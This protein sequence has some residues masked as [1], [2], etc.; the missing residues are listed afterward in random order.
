MEA[1]LSYQDLFQHLA[2]FGESGTGKSVFLTNLNLRHSRNGY[3]F[4]VFDYH[5]DVVR[6]IIAGL[7]PERVDDTIL[8]DLTD[9]EFPIGLNLCEVEGT[10]TIQSVAATASFIGHLF[11]VLF[12]TGLAT[13]PRLLEVLRAV[14]RTL[15]EVSPEACFT[16]IPLLFSD[17]NVRA[18]V[19]S[20]LTNASVVAFWEAY[21][22]LSERGKQEL[23]ES[24]RNKITAFTDEPLVAHILGQASSTIDLGRIMQEGKILLVKLSP[25]YEQA[26]QLV[27]GALLTKLMM[28]GFARA[29][30]PEEQRRPFMLTV[31]EF[32]RV[33]AASSDLKT[34]IHE[35]RKF[36]VGTTLATQTLQSLDEGTRAAALACGNLMV[37]RVSGQD[38][39]VLARSFDATPEPTPQ[40]IVPEPLLAP[41]GDVLTHLLRHG[42]SDPRITAFAQTS[43]HKLE[44]FVQH[45]NGRDR[46]QRELLPQYFASYNCF[47][48]ALLLS[49]RQVQEGREQ[50]NQTLY[51]A[52]LE[53]RAALP[54]PLLAFYILAVAQGDGREFCL[55]RHLTTA[56][57][58]EFLG[59]RLLVGF[60]ESAE[61]FGDPTLFTT[62]DSCA[63]YINSV[64]KRE[65][66][67]AERVMALLTELRYCMA[68][69]GNA[70]LLTPSGQYQAKMQPRAYA[71]MTNQRANEL[72]QLPNFQARV[73]FLSAGEGV[74]K[75]KPLPPL[76]SG[77]ALEAR[78]QRIKRRNWEEGYTRYY[79]DVEKDIR[80]RVER[81]RRPV[82]ETRR[83]GR[84]PHDPPP[85]SA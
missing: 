85:T 8:I 53:R 34:F 63:R 57:G 6:N 21:N 16:E 59:P 52:M 43:L 70:P 62:P 56:F 2:V 15:I 82:T 72:S 29:S 60:Q 46:N 58:Y 66:W 44:H 11:E 22:R 45:G 50:L 67:M 38:A 37:F 77:A 40:H 30:L 39:P 78:I 42:H 84:R 74:V 41:V 47:A 17:E 69:L 51:R 5:G 3:G 18:K 83:P 55:S 68:V 61:K 48:G 54:F 25:L 23:I 19:V 65:R 14:V 31:D 32:Q 80:E 36:R 73:R 35:A 71:D 1:G 10:H 76:L 28:A 49:E 75:T 7:P 12:G 81:L 20:R 9:A 33:A 4:C 26:S 13:T 79:K 64:P 27:G 24:T